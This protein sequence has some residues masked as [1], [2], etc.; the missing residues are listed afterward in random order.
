MTRE[1]MAF[2]PEWGRAKRIRRDK[3]PRAPRTCSARSGTGDERVDWMPNDGTLANENVNLGTGL[4][5]R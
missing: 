2:N 3:N 1:L 5:T 4:A